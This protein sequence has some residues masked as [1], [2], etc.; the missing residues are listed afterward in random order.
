MTLT[1]PPPERPN[2]AEA[3]L[4][5]TENSLIDS[6]EIDSGARPSAAPVVPPKKALL[7]ST[8]STVMLVLMP[9]WPEMERLPRSESVRVSGVS[10]TSCLKSVPG[11]GRFLICSDWMVVPIWV[12]V[13]STVGASAVTV[14]V[15]D[16]RPLWRVK[17]TLGVEPMSRRTLSAVAVAK[18]SRVAVTL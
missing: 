17:L 15:S 9:R 1:K 8:P 16:T 6:W 14:I 5:I 11:V 13:T 7:K 2:S 18:P 12:L 10:S 4:V 3:P